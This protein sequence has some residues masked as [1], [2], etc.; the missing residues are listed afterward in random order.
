MGSRGHA[1]SLAPFVLSGRGMTAFFAAH[2]TLFGLFLQFA[3]MLFWLVVLTAAFVP[4]ERVFAVKPTKLFAKGWGT[5]LVWYFV[6]GLVPVF[7]LGPPVALIAFVTHA[8]LPASFTSTVA[9][10]PLWTRM[11]AAMVVGELG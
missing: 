8:I 11:I 3:R 10:L 6:N 1:A 4:L 9:G 5:N 2:Q 7:L